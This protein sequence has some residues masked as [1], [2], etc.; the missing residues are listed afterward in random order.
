MNLDM[1]FSELRYFISV[2]DAQEFWP[3]TISVFVA[4]PVLSQRRRLECPQDVFMIYE[5][6]EPA[7]VKPTHP[8]VNTH[9]FHENASAE[10]KQC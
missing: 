4:K 6:S 3:N 9:S 5:T 8:L 1:P 2:R 7:P 10:C